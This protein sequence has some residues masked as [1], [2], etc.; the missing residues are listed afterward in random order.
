MY[1]PAVARN[2]PSQPPFTASATVVRT[3][4]A[5]IEH[6]LIRDAG[7]LQEDAG[8]EL[9]NHIVGFLG[10]ADHPTKRL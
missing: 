8:A 3:I 2:N 6:P 1:A 7:H 10:D 9:A 5:T 4:S